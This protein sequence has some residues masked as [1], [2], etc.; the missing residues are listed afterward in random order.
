ME[1]VTDVNPQLTAEN[2]ADEK[3]KMVANIDFKMVSFSLAGKDYAID[4]MR[5]KEIAKAGRFTYVP[6][7]SHFVLGVYNLRGDIIPIIDLRLFFNIPVPERS[8][9]KI[10]NMII[11]SI[12]DQTFGVVV[13]AIDKVV[14]IQ[15]S[16]I[17]PPHPLF[18]DINIKYIYGVV[19]N[20]DR[21]YILLD[22]ERIFGAK[23]AEKD[24]KEGE[25]SAQLSLVDPVSNGP[26]PASVQNQAAPA[27]SGGE[28][29]APKA[30]AAPLTKPVEKE[31]SDYT[32]ILESL[33]SQKKFYT[34]SINE[35]WVKQRYNEWK[36]KSGG[37]AKQLQTVADCD[38]FLQPF[39]ST[40]T[41]KFWTEEYSQA[42]YKLLPDN[43]AKQINVW[44]L[45]CGKGCET[46]SLACILRKRY[47]ES[48]IRIYAHDIDLISISNA[49]MLTV[50]DAAVTS[51]L[52]PYLSKNVSGA[53]A[54]VQDIKDMILFEYHDCMN[55]GN[56]PS[57]D[58]I[59]CRDV[60][61]F[62]PEKSQS[63]IMETFADQLKGNGLLILGENESF[64]VN[65]NWQE[66]MS[67][68]IVVYTK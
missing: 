27:R 62:L 64:G 60:L 33:A 66:K 49:P 14:G 23:S 54:F 18:G 67:G 28:S 39:Y 48:R 68:S 24:D 53:N 26:K 58:L 40:C 11:V 61:S 12:D 51:Y 19:E 42:I 34:T 44:N 47:P 37:T 45:G 16:S 21:L 8:E 29:G 13:D 31:S 50:P 30:S 1:L 5:V 32:F 38:E 22:I 63:S 59:F 65:G 46:Y 4:I 7:T 41:G 15:K 2:I 10:E 20:S 17:Q 55:T 52:K 56:M 35:T 9:N 43:A 57:S 25:D 6:N 36:E 3:E